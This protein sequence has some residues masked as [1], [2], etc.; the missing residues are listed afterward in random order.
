[1]DFLELTESIRKLIRYYEICNDAEQALVNDA[2]DEL[3]VL[4]KRIAD[5]E[6]V[7]A[8]EKRKDES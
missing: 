7:V 1:M 8:S 2:R 5:L 3:D 6:T 4:K